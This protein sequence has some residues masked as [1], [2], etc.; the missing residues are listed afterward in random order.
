MIYSTI[1]C[2]A[3]FHLGMNSFPHSAEQKMVRGQKLRKTTAGKGKRRKC[4]LRQ[5]FVVAA[6]PHFL[7]W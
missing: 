4:F 5:L 1:A 7:L 2:A 6:R 3:S